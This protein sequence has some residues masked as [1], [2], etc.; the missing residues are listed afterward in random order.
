MESPPQA[1]LAEHEEVMRF[2]DAKK[3]YGLGLGWIDINLLASTLLSQATLWILD[4]KLHNAA[5]WLK[6]SA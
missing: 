1:H 2:L 5:L 6:I 3:L 4:K